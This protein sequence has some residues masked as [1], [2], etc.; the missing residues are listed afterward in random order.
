MRRSG[1]EV[2][3]MQHPK[4]LR[5]RCC[6]QK[7]G[8]LFYLPS[9]VEFLPKCRPSTWMAMQSLMVHLRDLLEDHLD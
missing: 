2:G 4:V 9:H 1:G 7:L 5:D 3:W 6:I 8:N